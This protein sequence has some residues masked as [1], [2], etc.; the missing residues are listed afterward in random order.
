MPIKMFQ[1]TL[2]QLR[3]HMKQLMLL[4]LLLLV[5]RLT[6]AS[7][8]TNHLQPSTTLLMLLLWWVPTTAT[9]WVVFHLHSLFRLYE[10]LL[11][12]LT[13][14]YIPV[15]VLTE[16]LCRL[17]LYRVLWINGDYVTY[18]HLEECL[19]NA[20]WIAWVHEHNL[21]QILYTWSQGLNYL[22]CLYYLKRT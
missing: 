7:A 1:L 4:Q 12:L 18:A 9:K 19:P 5:N 15:E 14:K 17:I 20:L 8:T 13:T 22:I 3:R 6:T 10:C 11:N 16:Y 2:T 21:W